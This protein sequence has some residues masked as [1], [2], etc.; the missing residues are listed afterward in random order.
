MIRNWANHFKKDKTKFYSLHDTLEYILNKL[1]SKC[2]RE[3]ENNNRT[4]VQKGFVKFLIVH[5]NDEISHIHKIVL[6]NISW[7]WEILPL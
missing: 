6:N 3:N 7:P 5:P 2:I 4:S 1:K